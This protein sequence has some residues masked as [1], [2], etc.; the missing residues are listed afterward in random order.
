[1][2][3]YALAI[4][5]VF[6]I[7][8]CNNDKTAEVPPVIK[9]PQLAAFDGG[10]IRIQ[11]TEPYQ[12]IE[13]QIIVT[14]DNKPIENGTQFKLVADTVKIGDDNVNWLSTLIVSSNEG[15]ISFYVKPHT[16]AGLYRVNAIL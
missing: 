3:S 12:L 11:A 4:L 14:D 9:V 7:L 15:K 6:S 1:M 5:F 10:S 8:G 13:S 16:V 2:K